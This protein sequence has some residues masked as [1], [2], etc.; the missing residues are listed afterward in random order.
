MISG[1][2]PPHRPRPA[3]APPGGPLPLGPR[4]SQPGSEPR[5]LLDAW[6]SPRASGLLE[7]NLGSVHCWPATQGCIRILFSGQSPR[8]CRPAQGHFFEDLLE[9]Q[10]SLGVQSRV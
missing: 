3:A 4:G 10:T 7:A 8:K 1:G 6:V 9:T 5:P 2:R